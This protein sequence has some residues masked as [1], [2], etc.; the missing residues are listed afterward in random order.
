MKRA[1]ER[2]FRQRARR[3]FAA[4][5]A[6]L[7]LLM[8]AISL[9]LPMPA[10]GGMTSWDLALSPC[11]MEESG[12]QHKMPAPAPKDGHCTVCTVMLQA[13]ST[14]APA[15]APLVCSPVPRR[16][17]HQQIRRIQIAGLPARAFSS[18]APPSAA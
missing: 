5:V 13:G 18:R 6:M 7:A 14:L 9:Y 3:G 11:P 12:A 15:D 10:M 17:E 4:A 2:F 1:R 8:Q 16:V